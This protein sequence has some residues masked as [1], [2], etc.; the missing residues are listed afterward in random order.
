ME[1]DYKI[2]ISTQNGGESNQIINLGTVYKEYG[3]NIVEYTNYAAD[4][5][6]KTK[7]VIGEE[8]VTIINYGGVDGVINL[9]KGQTLSSVI[10]TGSMQ[11]PL[12]VKLNRLEKEITENS[13]FLKV[14]YEIAYFDNPENF[15]IEL[16]AVKIT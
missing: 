13:I 7:V 12:K 14:E 2:T 9:E 4:F 16:Q 1:N 15:K 6:Y 3:D 11:I 5:T 10:N 8:I